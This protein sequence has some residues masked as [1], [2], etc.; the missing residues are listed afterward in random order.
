M[1][2]EYNRDHACLGCQYGCT[3]RDVPLT[4][5]TC[6]KTFPARHYNGTDLAYCSRACDPHP[7]PWTTQFVYDHDYAP[8]CCET[9]DYLHARPR[10]VGRAEAA[11]LGLGRRTMRHD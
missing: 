5:D 6:G 7:Y 2:H 4:C 9:P 3:C 8:G 10:I 1:T 11:G